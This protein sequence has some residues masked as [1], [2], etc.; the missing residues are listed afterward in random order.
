MRKIF[1]DAVSY[2]VFHLFS[3]IDG[4]AD[5]QD[6]DEFWP[7]VKFSLRSENDSDAS[8]LHDEFYATY[9][10]WKKHTAT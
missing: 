10:E 3:L 5:P 8:N 9:D 1:L 2:P 4:V 6:Y 7:G